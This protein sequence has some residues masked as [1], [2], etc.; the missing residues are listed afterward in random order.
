M[1]ALAA[2]AGW[3]V[4]AMHLASV[5]HLSAGQ[6]A[7][8]NTAGKPDAE[9]DPNQA[10]KQRIARLVKQL[11]GKDVKKVF[12][13]YDE[14]M[15]IGRPAA[16]PVYRMARKSRSRDTRIRS[17][18]L[19]RE[20]IKR[21]KEK[22]PPDKVDP[23]VYTWTQPVGGVAMRLSLDRQTARPEH[24]V[25]LRVDFR[26]TAKE[27]VPFAPLTAVNTPRGGSS[28]AEGK[29]APKRDAKAFKKRPYKKHPLAMELKPGQTVTYRFRLN[30]KLGMQHKV[31]LMHEANTRQ[32]AGLPLAKVSTFNWLLPKGETEIQFTYYAASKGLLKGAE[33]NLS[34]TVTLTVSDKPDKP[35]KDKPSDAGSGS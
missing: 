1:M 10:R 18:V 5:S 22:A 9:V 4:A 34:Q 26:N 19:I 21:S 6:R 3:L 31:M 16:G 29:L 13:A 15:E 7:D 24:L 32:R 23:N 2:L 17:V 27:P 11:D 35:A 20:I 28:R 33:N 14:L 25:W 8:A 12:L 30:E